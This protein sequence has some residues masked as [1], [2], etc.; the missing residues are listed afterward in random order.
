MTQDQFLQRLSEEVQLDRAISAEEM[1][2]DI[3]EWDSLAMLATLN[4][5][6]EAGISIEIDDLESCKSVRDI[7]VKAGF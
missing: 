2:Y 7:L 1:L 3:P 4:V 5:F 6:D